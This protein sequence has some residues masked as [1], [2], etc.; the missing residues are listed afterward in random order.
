MAK[1]NLKL[2]L[3]YEDDSVLVEFDQDMLVRSL[4]E[5]FKQTNNI[6]EAFD[7]VVE[8][9]RQQTFKL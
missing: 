7:L 1:G 8:A 2:K 4:E 9:L 5:S 3:V 6:R